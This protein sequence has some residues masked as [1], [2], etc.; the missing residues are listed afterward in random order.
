MFTIESFY[1]CVYSFQCV[2]RSFWNFFPDCL[3]D[4]VV[5]LIHDSLA[6]SS[7]VSGL[8]LQP[9]QFLQGGKLPYCVLANLRKFQTARV[10]WQYKM[11][12]P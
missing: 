6:R 1:Y 4:K 11:K 9:A 12:S 7:C 2:C 8:Q 5:S 10:I 3:C